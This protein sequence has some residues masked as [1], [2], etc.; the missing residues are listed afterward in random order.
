VKHLPFRVSAANV[1]F[2]AAD[3]HSA[4]SCISTIAPIASGNIGDQYALQCDCVWCFSPQWQE[5]LVFESMI[6]VCLQ[7]R[8]CT[9]DKDVRRVML[10]AVARVSEHQ[11]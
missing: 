4:I 3:V 8:Y 11:V 5:D 1:S 9:V 10:C 7:I 6:A 2:G